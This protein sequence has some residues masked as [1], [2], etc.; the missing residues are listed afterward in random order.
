MK[1]KILFAVLG[2]ILAG[3]VMALGQVLMSSPLL[4]NAGP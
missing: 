4:R 2:T 1:K 3:V